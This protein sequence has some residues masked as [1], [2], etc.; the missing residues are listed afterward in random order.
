MR[1]D[2]YG[3]LRQASTPLTPLPA[4][5]E[6]FQKSYNTRSLFEARTLAPRPLSE[7]TEIFDT[8]FEEDE[9]DDDQTSPRSSIGSVSHAWIE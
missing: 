3:F 5:L 4:E 9:S 2:T 7:A 1:S 6:M 8:D